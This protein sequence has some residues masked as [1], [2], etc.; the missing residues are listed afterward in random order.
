MEFQSY[1][2]Y[3]TNGIQKNEILQYIKQY[4]THVK[5]N[6]MEH[7]ELFHIL[8]TKLKTKPFRMSMRDKRYCTC[9]LG[10]DPIGMI[11]CCNIG[12]L[13]ST[14]NYFYNHKLVCTEYFDN[15]RQYY[16][17]KDVEYVDLNTV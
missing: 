12:C 14:I 3:Y 5:E 2:L 10:N 9:I 15:H 11:M 17:K 4:N 1:T 7:Q 13:D 16:K 8:N 6:K